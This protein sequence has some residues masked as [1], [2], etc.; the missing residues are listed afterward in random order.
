MGSYTVHL[1]KPVVH[2]AS[3]RVPTIETKAV[4]VL[5]LKRGLGKVERFA[6]AFQVGFMQSEYEV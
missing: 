4:S 6:T 5:Y 3:L 1:P 2:G